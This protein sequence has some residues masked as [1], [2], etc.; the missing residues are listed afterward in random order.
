MHP[1]CPANSHCSP[2]VHGDRPAARTLARQPLSRRS[3]RRHIGQLRAPCSP[4]VPGC[5]A[6]QTCVVQLAAGSDNNCVRGLP[7]SGAGGRP[8]GRRAYHSVA[9]ASTHPSMIACRDRACCCASLPRSRA[10]TVTSLDA[11]M[12]VFDRRR[13]GPIQLSK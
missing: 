4:T 13:V 8:A 11:S 12:A 7:R 10:L 9:P 1:S 3:C 6:P 2:S 5:N